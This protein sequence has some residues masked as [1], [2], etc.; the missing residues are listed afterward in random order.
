L[1]DLEKEELLNL[2]KALIRD[3]YPAKVAEKIAAWY[4]IQR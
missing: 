3:G 4:V 1:I 2:K